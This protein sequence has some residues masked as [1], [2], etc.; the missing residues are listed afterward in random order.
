MR[1]VGR[2]FSV[3]AEDRVWLL[4][5][6][7]LR[8]KEFRVPRGWRRGCQIGYRDWKLLV[9]YGVAGKTVYIQ[10]NKRIDYRSIISK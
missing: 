9:K 3:G 8:G 5:S 4:L 1:K 10:K 7:R 2:Y 6:H